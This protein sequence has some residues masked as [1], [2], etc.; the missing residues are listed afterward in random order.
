PPGAAPARAGRPGRAGRRRPRGARHALPGGAG[1]R[2]HRG[3]AGPQRGGGQDAPPAGP[4]AAPRDVG[5]RGRGGAAMRTPQKGSASAV[6]ADRSLTDL[7]D[8]L[9]RKFQAGEPADL[10]AYLAA[11]PQHADQ[12]RELLPAVEVLA[13]LGR[14]ADAGEASVPPGAADLEAGPE[15][16]GDF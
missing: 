16:L 6:A 14:S 7:V 15:R 1:Q 9:A 12:L 10:E 2:G 8:E 11:Y 3:V 13:D 5:G 4:E